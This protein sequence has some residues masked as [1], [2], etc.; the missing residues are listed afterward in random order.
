MAEAIVTRSGGLIGSA[1]VD[2]LVEKGLTV[3]GS[4]NDLRRYFLAIK[5]R[6]DGVSVNLKPTIAI[7]AMRSACAF[8]RF[9]AH[10]SRGIIN[11]AATFSPRFRC[12]C[13]A[14]QP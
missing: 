11:Y 1:A 10:L 14:I 5:H 7:T 12:T 8:R 4:D 9:K 13:S 2:F 3:I 6:R